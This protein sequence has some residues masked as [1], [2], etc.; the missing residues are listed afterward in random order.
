MKIRAGVTDKNWY[1]HLIRF[2]PEEVTF[3]QPSGSRTFRVSL[4]YVKSK[5]RQIKHCWFQE[6]QVN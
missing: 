3:W 6:A 1:E 4:V 5:Q 2:A